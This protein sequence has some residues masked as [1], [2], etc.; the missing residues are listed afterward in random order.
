MT[1][2]TVSREQ[3]VEALRQVEDG[4]CG[5]NLCRQQGER[6]HL[7]R[8]AETLRA[9]RREEPRRPRQLRHENG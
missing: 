1:R 6:R 5:G 3:V 4:R 8:V 7:L 9:L 2:S